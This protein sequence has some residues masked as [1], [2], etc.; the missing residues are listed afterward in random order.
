MKTFSQSLLFASVVL[1][2]SVAGSNE[3]NAIRSTPSNISI[4]KA[5]SW[6]SVWSGSGDIM[7]DRKSPPTDLVI[8]EWQPPCRVTFK[9]SPS[10]Q[11][12]VARMQV[13]VKGK[14]QTWF[15]G[16]VKSNGQGSFTLN[17]EEF[18][19]MGWYEFCDYRKLPYR[20]L[21]EGKKIKTEVLGG[22]GLLFIFSETYYDCQPGDTDWSRRYYEL[23][24]D[25]DKNA[26]WNVLCPAKGK[27]IFSHERRWWT[28][29]T[30]AGTPRYEC[31]WMK[32]Y[33]YKD[34]SQAPSELVS[35]WWNSSKECGS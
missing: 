23:G 27:P 17:D 29:T 12:R 5:C 31:R 21:V 32:F 14:W 1:G 22:N 11:P 35:E 3:T 15:D 4:S 9:A 26:C 7:E 8:A 33:T 18:N 25:P 6:K 20:I 34:G 19:P 28:G 16:K 2:L 24:E 10:K 13:N 30:R